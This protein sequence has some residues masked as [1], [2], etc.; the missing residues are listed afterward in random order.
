MIKLSVLGTTIIQ[1]EDGSVGH[2]ILSGPKRLAI[3]TYLILE[4]PRG[5][6]RRDEITAL[7]W[8]EM[9]QKGAR[10][11]LSN[12]L[13]HIR[14]S[15]GKDVIIN[16]G[17]EEVSLNMDRIWC[18]AIAFEKALQEENPRKALEIYHDD[19]LV[20]FHVSDVSNEFQN[21]LDQERNRLRV[22]ASKGAWEI[23]ENEEQKANYDAARRWAQKAAE[24]VPF[25]QEAQIRLITFLKRTGDRTAAR[26]AY[27]AFAKRLSKEWGMEPPEDV[28]KLVEE[29]TVEQA[30]A[31]ESILTGT[32]ENKAPVS[33][34]ERG[35]SSTGKIGFG[36]QEARRP[37][38]T[39]FLHR[40]AKPGSAVAAS[41][42]IL[43]LLW[44]FWNHDIING[45]KAT[46]TGNKSVAVLPF[47]YIGTEDS[48]DYFSLGITEEILTRLAQV[49]GLSVI[50]RTSV[51]QYQNSEKSLREIGRELGATAIV[52]GSVLH[53]GNR[54]R[55]NAQLIDAETDHHLWSK[56]YDRQVE[57]IFE[58]QSDI[59]KSIAEE[60]QAELGRGVRSRIERIPTKNLEAYERFLR[61]REYLH[62]TVKE[63]NKT[64]IRLL[65][66]AIAI[67]TDFALA[68][69]IL[70]KAYAKDA[71]TFGADAMWAD[72]AIAEAQRAVALAPDLHEAHLAL[73]YARMVAGR[74]SQAEESFIRA[75]ELNHNDWEAAN[76]LGIVYLQTGRMVQ[77]IQQWMRSLRGDPASAHGYR[78]NLALA[79]RILGMLDRA[80][81]YNDLSLALEPEFILATVNQAH[82]DLFRGEKTA[83]TEAVARLAV[84]HNE[85]PYALLSAGW[86]Y[87][88]AGETE[89]ALD[90][91]QRAYDLSPAASGE[92]YVRAR[93]GY[94]LWE[95]GK[96]ERAEQL[97]EEFEQFATEQFQ[98]GNEYGMLPYELAAV[99][100]VQGNTG[101]AL[102]LLE[103]ALEAGWPYELTLINDPMFASIRN[104]ERYQ[105][106]VR[107]MSERNERMRSQLRQSIVPEDTLMLQRD[108]SR[109]N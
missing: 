83:A 74:F 84:K 55:I 99:H 19:L 67:D 107:S 37:Y 1:K 49:S 70:S 21:W 52:E 25:S 65:Q 104:E 20:G 93:L 103:R 13:Y 76:K 18:D 57:N 43:V 94:A 41:A 47:T 96:V 71:W 22:L 90:P 29:D 59:S 10:N 31:K 105:A 14:E 61:G 44:V 6:R 85:N 51:M 100:S 106:V 63:E 80:E 27:D 16:R 12:I 50:S 54:I 87:I 88:L 77:A 109:L 73:G 7:F 95:A 64:A 32:N 45:S 26:E 8:P 5:F 35:A 9:G 40:F 23:A 62:R 17:T 89:K 69:A 46:V 48:T 97:F 79:Y 75:L 86:I 3:L 66:E 91:L 11:A 42:L 101:Q 92:G 58:V 102:G 2:S 34:E 4:K 24:Y 56:S 78:F 81:A 98:K 53:H 28:K 30:R 36:E 60:L 38:L 33:S 108:R 72:S 68:R 39:R 15:L 82:I